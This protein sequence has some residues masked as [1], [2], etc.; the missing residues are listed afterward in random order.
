MAVP[1]DPFAAG[2]GRVLGIDLGARRIG[3]AVGDIETHT[4]SP[5][6]TLSRGKT[7]ADDAAVLSRLAAEQGAA[8]LVVGLPLNMDGSEGPQA[9]LT[10]E[11]AEAVAAATGLSLRLRD[12]RLTSE[13]AEHRIGPAG[14]GRSG[15]PP[16]PARRDA[17]RAR[18]DREAAALILQD[19][20]DAAVNEKTELISG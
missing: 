16:S 13:R 20:L 6:A 4:A 8:V 1:V 3:I 14:R 5:F 12:E 17:Y 2:K 19:D 7:I 10:R 18:V 15:G 11:W 9:T